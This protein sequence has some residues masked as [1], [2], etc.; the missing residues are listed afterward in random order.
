MCLVPLFCLASQ[1][2]ASG[3]KWKLFKWLFKKLLTH[4]PFLILMNRLY[5]FWIVSWFCFLHLTDF[6]CL[7]CR[8]QWLWCSGN[9][10]KAQLL[11]V[12]CGGVIYTK[13]YTAWQCR[14]TEMIDASWFF[15]SNKCLFWYI[16]CGRHSSKCFKNINSFNLQNN[17]LILLLYHCSADGE[18]GT[19]RLSDF[20]RV[21]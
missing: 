5:V 16:W 8:A 17:A 15:S 11:I 4:N 14:V 10:R 9:Y 1:G 3:V 19:E 7:L 12:Q 20:P 13:G 2:E 6:E 21:A 18:T